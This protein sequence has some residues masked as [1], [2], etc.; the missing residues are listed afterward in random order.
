ME[1]DN[2]FMKYISSNFIKIKNDFKL[3]IKRVGLSFNEDIF[4]DTILKCNERLSKTKPEKIEMIAYFWTAFKMNTLR[5][6]S[7]V[8]NNTIDTIPEISSEEFDTTNE[9]F[10]AVSELII[11]K[12]G[13]EIYELFVLHSNGIKYEDLEKMTNIKHIKYLFRKVREYVRENY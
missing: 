12:F 8:R 7:Y 13:D 3:K 1:D 4:S 10:N 11:N 2:Y 9:K 6:L 5:E